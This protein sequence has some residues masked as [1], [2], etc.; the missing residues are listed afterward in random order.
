MPIKNILLVD[1]DPNIQ[2]I[3]QIGLEDCP[4]WKVSLASSGFEALDKLNT[5]KPDLKFTKAS[6]I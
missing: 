1:D 2:M 3:A 5:E 4:E 6:K